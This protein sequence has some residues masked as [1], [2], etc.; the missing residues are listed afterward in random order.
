MCTFVFPLVTLTEKFVK[1]RYQDLNLP[2]RILPKQSSADDDANNSPCLYKIR[3]R[4]GRRAQ[5]TDMTSR[6]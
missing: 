4:G 2:N 5:L 3:L 6:E 1:A